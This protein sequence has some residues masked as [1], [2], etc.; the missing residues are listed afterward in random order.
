MDALNIPPWFA[1]SLPEFYT[2]RVGWSCTSQ[3]VASEE[4][5]IY[6]SYNAHWTVARRLAHRDILPLPLR[7]RYPTADL[8]RT[9]FL[10]CR[11]RCKSFSIYLLGEFLLMKR[12]C[13]VYLQT[14]IFKKVSIVVC[15]VL[16]C[17]IPQ[18]SQN[19]SIQ[20]SFQPK[21]HMQSYKQ[22]TLLNHKLCCCRCL[23]LVWNL[24]SWVNRQCSKFPIVYLR[25]QLLH[26]NFLLLVHLKFHTIL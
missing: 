18:A 9:G 11:P 14:C 3:L 6:H 25:M 2:S 24:S 16:C 12:S 8:L 17:L 15:K 23:H 7:Q 13:S 22:Y 26:D 4:F 20:D 21:S 19:N 10:S 5:W 1:I